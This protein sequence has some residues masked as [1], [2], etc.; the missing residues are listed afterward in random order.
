VLLQFGIGP[1]RGFAITLAL[2]IIAS[3]FS[4][5]FI[6][7]VIMDAVLVRPAVNKLSI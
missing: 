2:G 6:A 3:M 7:R 5:L 4:A 1:I